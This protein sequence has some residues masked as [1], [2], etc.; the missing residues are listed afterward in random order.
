[1]VPPIRRGGRL[2]AWSRVLRAE[3]VERVKESGL[4]SQRWKVEAVISVIK[5]KFG[6][7][8]RSRRLRLV[9]CEVL[10]KGVGNKLASQFFVVVRVWYVRW[11]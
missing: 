9:G 5:R 4:Y 6:A 3:L 7:G 10:A 11:L 2:R 1:M 8:V